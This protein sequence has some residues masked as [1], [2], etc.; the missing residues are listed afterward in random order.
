MLTILLRAVA[1]QSYGGQLARSPSANRC[2]T[3]ALGAGRHDYD[4][5][6]IGSGF[7]GSASRPCASPR[8]ATGSRS[9]SAAGATGDE[10]FAESAWNLRRYFW[11]PR[12][13][14]RGDLPDDALQ[15]RLHRL[16]LRGRRRQ[17]RLRQHPLPGPARLLP[18]PPVGGLAD[19]ERE[20]APHYDTAERMLG[21]TDYQGMGPADELLREYG[22][23]IG[24]GDTF[25][26]TRVGVFFGEPGKEVEDPYFGGEGPPRSGCI[27]CGSCMVG[28]RHG[29]KNT[30]VKNYLWFAEKLGVEVLPERQV[31]DIRPA[32]RRRTAATATR[33][34]SRRSGAWLQPQA[35]PDADGARG[36]GRRGSPRHQQAA[37]RLPAPRLAAAALATA[38]ATS[39]GPTRSRSRRSPLPTTSRDFAKSVAITSSIYPDPDTHIEVVTYGR[40]GD[41]MSGLFTAAG[42]SGHEGDPAAEVD[43]SDARASAPLASPALAVRL[44]A[45]HG[46]PA[47]HADRRRRHAAA[48][49]SDGSW[50]GHTAADR[51]GSRAPEPDLHPGGGRVAE[52]F[53]ERTGGIRRV[54]AHRVDLQHP[55][56]GPHPRRRRDRRLDPSTA[57][58]TPATASSATRT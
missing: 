3:C 41:A 1:R 36:R 48:S 43:R 29:A 51:A 14:L 31:T 7:G 13:G 17:P 40:G 56:D 30:L 24:V 15:G 9:S 19:W 18:R 26:P 6:V 35:P 53:A 5:I 27:R 21:V 37:R 52:W 34:T 16:R 47:G 4:W 42:W 38:S 55:D 25:K 45:A 39:S 50:A 44:V 28:C 22:E 57:W 10:D 23:E 11:M 32:R 8:R 33:V 12:L 58:S 46:D 20:L 49:R 54:G 2:L